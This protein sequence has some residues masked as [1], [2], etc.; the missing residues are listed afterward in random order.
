[1]EYN[2]EKMKVYIGLALKKLKEMD[3][4]LGRME[5]KM[6][7]FSAT[8]QDKITAR[9]KKLIQQAQ[10]E[11]EEIVNILREMNDTLNIAT[12]IF[13]DNEKKYGG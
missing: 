2:S 10:H 3:D 9:A 5:G 6:D 1:M 12:N 13:E 7:E 8:I 4:E 11:Q